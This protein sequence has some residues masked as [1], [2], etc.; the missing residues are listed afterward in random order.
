[1]TAAVEIY[2]DMAAFASRRVPAWHMLGE[3]FET[4]V[5]TAEMLEKAHLN[6]WDIHLEEI[7]T[8]HFFYKTA[9][10]VVRTNPFTGDKEILGIVGE[11][12]NEV[13]NEEL[14]AFGDN[15]IHGG[16]R[17]ETA[18]SIKNG[19]VVFAS[20]AFDKQGRTLGDDDEVKVYLLLHTSHDGSLAVQASI[21]PVRVV[22]QNTLNM[23]LSGAKQTFKIRHTSTVNGKVQA[24]REALGL[25]DTYLKR[26]DEVTT[27]LLNTKVDDQK[28]WD[29]VTTLYPQPEKD[30]KGALTKWTNKTDL[31][32][33]TWNSD[34][35]ENIRGTGWGA[36]NALTERLDWFRQIRGG[37]VE[38][39]YSAASGFDAV[40]N[41]EKN[42]IL[43]AVATLS[44]SGIKV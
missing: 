25:A 14:L 17:W 8:P 9:Y 37:N 20:L 40:T 4:D 2:G 19:T 24:A 29:I 44:G 10:Y 5:T 6:G 18:G 43:S 11:R 7:Q 23:A 33:A 12:Y 27:G 38:N 32:V 1:M 3:V 31:I 34:T 30:V 42:R 16:G 36:V 22:C 13:Q 41:A 15:I 35:V 28:F 39:A 21:T 26:F